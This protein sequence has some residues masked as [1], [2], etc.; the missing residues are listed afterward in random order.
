VLPNAST[1]MGDLQ[2]R[3]CF[4]GVKLLTYLG[5]GSRSPRSVCASYAYC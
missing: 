1:V 4:L 2:I 3:F 5:D